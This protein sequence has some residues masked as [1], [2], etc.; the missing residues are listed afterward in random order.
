VV[1]VALPGVKTEDINI[2][3][4]GDTL[5]IMGDSKAEEEVKR[6]DYLYQKRRYGAFSRSMV[7]PSG[8]KSDKAEEVK[9]GMI[10]VR[11]KGK[12]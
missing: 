9:P 3:I 5:T 7:L 10:K 1:K 4:T 6:K 11:A 2:D 8:L 12:K